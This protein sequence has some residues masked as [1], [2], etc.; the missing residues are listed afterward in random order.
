MRGSLIL[1]SLLL[2]QGCQSD[3]DKCMQTEGPRAEKAM[4]I[5]QLASDLTRFREASLGSLLQMEFAIKYNELYGDID[6]PESMP[7]SPDYPGYA[8][9]D[10]K[11]DE[12]YECYAE[13]E[14]KEENY[15]KQKAQYSVDL[16]IWKQ[17]PAGL[18]WS[19]D[20]E[21]RYVNAWNETGVPGT[22]TEEVNGW[23]DE[24]YPED[25]LNF[26]FT[27]FENYAQEFNCWGEGMEYCYDP[28]GAKVKSESKLSYGDDGFE[29][30]YVV[31]L[32][33]TVA[34]VLGKLT[35]AY[36]EGAAQAKE[37]AILTCNQNGFYK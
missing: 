11:G 33:S 7:S 2:L 10:L 8:C 37:L 34:I 17:T 24:K 28:I 22:S 19:R 29:E 21:L 4:G 1:F 12:W 36:S 15:E 31:A 6:S 30:K 18:S 3:F 5:F 20:Q 16:E 23:F 25:E 13:H 26:V 14:K 27:E 32:K 9:T 35:D